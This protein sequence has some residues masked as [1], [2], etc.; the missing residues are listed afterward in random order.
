[1]PVFELLANNGFT[2]WRDYFKE[3]IVAAPDCIAVTVSK[4]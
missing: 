3:I 1:M 2:E 4:E